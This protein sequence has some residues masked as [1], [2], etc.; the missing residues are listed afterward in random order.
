VETDAW[1][2]EPDGVSTRRGLEVHFFIETPR[3]ECAKFLIS[4][5]SLW[6]LQSV[7]GF[8]IC[9]KALRLQAACEPHAEAAD[10][11]LGSVKSSP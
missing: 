6:L 10:Q 5:P 1:L 4:G 8:T 3:E 11:V 7:P 2:T 9:L